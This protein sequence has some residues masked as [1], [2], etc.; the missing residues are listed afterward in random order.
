[1]RRGEQVP[2]GTVTRV[3]DALAAA[4]ETD[5]A[6]VELTFVAETAALEAA[7]ELDA[8]LENQQLKQGTQTR[9]C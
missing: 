9:H 6:T 1:M 3:L 8:V 2:D 7:L 4:L 5:G